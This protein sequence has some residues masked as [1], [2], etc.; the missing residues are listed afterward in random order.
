LLYYHP[1][2]IYRYQVIKQADVVLAM[3]LLNHI[4][5]DAQKQRNFDYYDPLT[6]GDSS[7]SACIQSI[8]AAEI[9]E[10]R[11]AM[12]YARFAVLMDLADIG[13]NMAD[14]CH[15]ASMGGTW[16]VAVYGFAGMRD[17]NGRISFDP[18]L[19]EPIE[20]LRF[21]LQI[22][23]KRLVVS[24]TRAEASYRLE[25][26]GELEISHQGMPLTLK[27]GIEFRCEIKAGT[28]AEQDPTA[29]PGAEETGSAP[30]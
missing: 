8:V 5:T 12:E 30:D 19:P 18:L 9:G 6:T 13:G 16:M 25:E 23:G 27:E 22:R 15:I 11:K 17:Y 1:L 3:L 4:F 10:S 2:V 26:G 28:A 29:A 21:P 7:L 14:G 24:V 20:E